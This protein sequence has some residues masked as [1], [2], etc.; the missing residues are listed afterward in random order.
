[1]YIKPANLCLQL[2]PV[3]RLRYPYSGQVL[4][5]HVGDGRHV[6]PCLDKVVVI[7]FIVEI[8]QPGTQHLMV[9]INENVR[10]IIMF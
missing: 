9:L 3:P 6:V 1:M 2:L 7:F 8:A 10:F 5:G 4:R